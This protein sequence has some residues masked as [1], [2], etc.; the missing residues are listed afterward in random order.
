MISLTLTNK[1]VRIEGAGEK[2]LK[3]L[4]TLTSYYVE[5]YRFSPKYPRQWDGKEHLLGYYVRRD[6]S[7]YYCPVGLVFDLIDAL[8]GAG[9]AF[10]VI[11]RRVRYGENLVF[12][13]NPKVLMRPYQLEAVEAMSR[14][15]LPGIGILKMPPRSGKTLTT[16]RLIHE[17]CSTTLAIVPS[18]WLLHQTAQALELALGVPVGKLGDN[19]WEVRDITVATIGTLHSR[20]GGTREKKVQGVLV[21]YKVPRDPQYTALLDSF[22][23]VVFDEVHHLRGKE[24]HKVFG[25]FNAYFRVGLSATAFPDHERERAKGAIWLKAY[26]GQIRFEVSPSR[27]IEEGFLMRPTIELYRVTSPDCS[28]R[29]WDGDLV[30]ECIYQNEVRNDLIARVAKELCSQG[31]KVLIVTNRKEQGRILADLVRRRGLQEGLVFGD[32]PTETR[33]AYVK[34]LVGGHINVLIGTVFGEGVDIP[35]VEAVI[36]AEGGRDIKATF[37]RMRNLTVSKGKT[38]A[39]FVDFLDLTN[40]YL[41]LHSLDRLRVYRSEPSFLIRTV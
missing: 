20:R 28:E 38:K 25:D 18:V 15:F 14:G 24:W 27:L 8:K 29:P 31:L 33:Q 4:D 1:Y 7:G 5:G 36:N 41:T 12:E 11:D 30:Q 37:Q 16:A 6:P 3:R 26:C 9:E 40:P 35:E 32:T 17:F 23:L 34:M 21:K 22:D 19:C 2:L 13:W 39:V 10:E